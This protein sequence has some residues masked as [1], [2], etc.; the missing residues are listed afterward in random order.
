MNLHL[1]IQAEL[2]QIRA[3]RDVF[4]PRDVVA[5][6]RRH[7]KSALHTQF[8]WDVQKAAEEHWLDTARRLI[9]L[10]IVALDGGPQMV[11]LSIDRHPGGGYRDIV[12]VS[13]APSLYKVLLQDAIKE[14]KRVQ[15]KY[16]RVKELSKLWRLIDEY[17]AEEAKKGKKDAA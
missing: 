14:L 5:Y 13:K 8:Q 2:L 9:T 17:E 12:E 10:H 6:A 3:G 11:S 4:P 1:R 15:A 7:K 16:S